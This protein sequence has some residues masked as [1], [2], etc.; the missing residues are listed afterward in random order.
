MLNKSLRRII[1]L[2]FGQKT[3][4]VSFDP[5][6]FLDCGTTEI[7]ARGLPPKVEKALVDIKENGVAVLPGNISHEDCDAVVR[8]FNNYISNSDEAL[9]YRDEHGLHERLCNLQ[10]ISEAARRICFNKGTAEILQAAFASEFTVVGSLFFEKGSTQSIHRDTPAFFTNPLNHYFGVWNALEDI[11]VGSG[12]LMY[13]AGGHKLVSDQSLYLDEKITINNYFNAVEDACKKAGLELVEIYPKKGDTLIWHP[14]LPHGGGK[15]ANKGSS[16]RSLV[17]HC[18]PKKTPIYGTD[19]F[20]DPKHVVPV[21]RPHKTMPYG[22][23]EMLD[24]GAPRFFHN[25]YEGNFDEV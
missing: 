21:A 13:Y 20:F 16:R 18:I 19:E 4:R 10:L 2:V 24:Q 11:E 22:V 15:I 17:F 25:R 3:T 1:N 8:D 14:Q 5:M 6:W 7:K 23:N 12:P 9:K